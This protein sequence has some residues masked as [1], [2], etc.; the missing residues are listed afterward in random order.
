MYI[1]A[2]EVIVLQNIVTVDLFK[3]TSV[4]VL[5]LTFFFF[6]VKMFL[7]T[8]PLKAINTDILYSDQISNF[9]VSFILVFPLYIK[10]MWLS[11]PTCLK[12]FFPFGPFVVK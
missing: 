1:F 4:F 11:R 12:G 5:A 8:K 6:K 2:R 3:V 7:M 9:I 10:N